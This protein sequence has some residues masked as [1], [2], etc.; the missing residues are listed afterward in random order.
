METVI[1]FFSKD[2]L[3][4]IW[5]LRCIFFLCGRY[6]LPLRS[7]VPF[8]IFLISSPLPFGH[9]YGLL[10]VLMVL[11]EYALKQ[12]ELFRDAEPKLRPQ[13]LFNL[14]AKWEASSASRGEIQSVLKLLV[15]L[16]CTNSSGMIGS[17]SVKLWSVFDLS[18]LRGHCV[19]TD[20]CVCVWDSWG[21]CLGLVYLHKPAY[22]LREES[23]VGNWGGERKGQGEPL[24]WLKLII[25]MTFNT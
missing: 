20:N 24:S 5:T 2:R 7:R 9:F 4:Y 13:N 10:K 18:G 15:L 21:M 17:D 22:F 19:Q 11:I 8:L 12:P 16:V 1:I 25:V 23:G 6:A 3:I 14:S